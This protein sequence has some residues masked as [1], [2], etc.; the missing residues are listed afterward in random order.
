MGPARTPAVDRRAGIST[1]FS[2]VELLIAVVILSLVIGAGTFGFSLFTKHWARDREAFDRRISSFQRLELVHRALEDAIPW[3]VR[4]Q[5]GK[6]GFYFLGRDEGLTLVTGS[7]IFNPG[8]VAVIRFFRERAGPDE[9]RLVYEEAPLVGVRLREAS[10]VLPFRHRLVVL[11]GLKGDVSFRY[12]GWESME[13]RLRESGPGE[14]VPMPRWFADYDGLQRG[15]HPQRIGVSF[16]GAEA[17][18]FVPDRGN[19]AINRMIVE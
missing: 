15:Q 19:A 11:R 5:S 12:F 4:A 7:P 6:I 8:R 13:D 9:W 16:D 14:A 17:I 2:L 10:Q 3:A 18:Y 1:G